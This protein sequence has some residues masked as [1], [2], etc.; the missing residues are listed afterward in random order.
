MRQ[1]TKI[2]P[3]PAKATL[4][5]DARQYPEEYREH[6]ARKRAANARDGPRIALQFV[7]CRHHPCTLDMARR[8]RID[9]VHLLHPRWELTESCLL[10]RQTGRRVVEETDMK[11]PARVS[12]CGRSRQR[13]VKLPVVLEED[14]SAR[15]ARKRALEARQAQQRAQ[16]HGR[17]AA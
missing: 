3:C 2:S 5:A 8:Q 11:K 9:Q 6:C 13:L 7:S 15:R 10:D 4:Q 1:C 12:A 17:R 16:R 14:C